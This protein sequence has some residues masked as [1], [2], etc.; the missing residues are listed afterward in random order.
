MMATAFGASTNFTSAQTKQ[1]QKII[2]NY[3][4]NH[5]QIL[6]QVS[7]ALRVKQMQAEQKQALAGTKANANKI[8]NAP[9]SP[10]AGN[11]KS[12]IIVVEFFDYQCPHCRDM[13]QIMQNILKQ[14]PTI[15]VIYKEFPIFGANSQ[16]ASAAALAA[17]KQGK[18]ETVHNAL[19]KATAPITQKEV[20]AIVKKAGLNLVLL[21]KDMNSAAVKAELNQN[22]QLAQALH[23]IGT[24]AFIV[25]NTK[26]NAY[27]FMPGAGSQQN[28]QDLINK[29]K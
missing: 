19:F 15:K 1:I 8:F 14:N 26:T 4:I 28:L 22:S 16:Y 7:Q 20:L 18:Y 9:A 11:P 17:N 12:N 24:P 10:V 6:V 3:L 21:K 2:R 23:L 25:A 13:A 29:V 5:P 27:Q